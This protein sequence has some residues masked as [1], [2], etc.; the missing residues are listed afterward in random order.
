M[1]STG[2]SVDEVAR[3]YWIFVIVFIHPHVRVYIELIQRQLGNAMHV[4]PSS[5]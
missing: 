3:Q 1:S 5:A 2:E 4:D